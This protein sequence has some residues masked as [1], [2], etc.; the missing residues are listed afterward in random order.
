[1]NQDVP[2]EES[3]VGMDQTSGM[4]HASFQAVTLYG[5]QFL[6]SY[7]FFAPPSPQVQAPVEVSALVPAP[8]ETR[9]FI[10]P[11]A[12]FWFLP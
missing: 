9:S 2:I 1:M 5:Q 11:K 10:E 12:M 3:L 4:E 6:H 7:I 8:Y